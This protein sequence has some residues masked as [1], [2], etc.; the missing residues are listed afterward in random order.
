M[1]NNGIY[2]SFSMAA[3]LLIIAV[4]GCKK[5]GAEEI[6][7]PEID[8]AEAFTD[9]VT[10]YKSYPGVLMA[11]TTAQVVAQVNGRLLSAPY[12][13]GSYVRK[14]QV[15]FTIDPTVY[16]NA[17]TRAEAELE[18]ARSQYEYYTK[19]YAALNKA[20]EAD[21]VSKMEVLQ[22]KSNMNQAEA[23][24]RDAEA[25]LSTARVNLSHCTITAPVPG[26]ISNGAPD[27]GNYIAGENS[28]QVFC[29]IYDNAKVLANFYLSDTQYEELIGANGGI[30]APIYRNVPVEFRE[31]MKHSYTTD[32]NFI[33]PTVSQSTG[34]MLLRGEIINVDNELKDGMYITISLPYGVDANAVLVKD[35]SIG[36]DQLGKYLYT[37]NDSNK[38]V[39]TPIQ[40]GELYH[41]SLRMVTSGIRP[42]QKYV[43]KA[44]LKVRRGERIK[45][46]LTK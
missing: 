18:T 14:G 1:K 2:T 44:L 36:S 32:L 27:V 41:D 26:Y 25:A 20:L 37:V 39:Y 42:G 15:L 33:S 28:P 22:A 43:T 30:D 24:I 35:A 38:V 23:S 16:R 46:I 12:K 3:F 17:V 34:T 9:S 5:K 6:S 4:A 13:A 11:G 8:V 21:A 45:P 19:Q 10:L 31:N 40:T 29:T 7:V